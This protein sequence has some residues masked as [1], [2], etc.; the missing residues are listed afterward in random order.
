MRNRDRGEIVPFYP[1][2]ERML[3]ARKREALLLLDNPLFGMEDP[4]NTNP[5]DND[6][7]QGEV[8]QPRRGRGNGNGQARRTLLD[9]TRSEPI[10]HRSGVRRLTVEAKNFEIKLGLIQMVKTNPFSGSEL[11][12]PNEHLIQFF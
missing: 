1:K 11:E 4:E 2:I 7:G 3:R 6:E 10:D 5:I 9:L 8:D 12:D